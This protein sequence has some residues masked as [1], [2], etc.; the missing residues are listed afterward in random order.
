MTVIDPAA[1]VQD[2]DAWHEAMHGP[3]AHERMRQRRFDAMVD[4]RLEWPG[5]PS[6]YGPAREIVRGPLTIDPD[7]FER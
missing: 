2:F 1:S 3:E 5:F 7:R 4:K 6:F